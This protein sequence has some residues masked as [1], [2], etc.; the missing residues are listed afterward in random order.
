MPSTSITSQQIPLA[1]QSSV[2]SLMPPYVHGSS[3]SWSPVTG[4]HLSASNSS[5]PNA[6]GTHFSPS[7]QS[8]ANGSHSSSPQSSDPQSDIGT[9]HVPELGEPVSGHESVSESEVEVE[10]VSA[11]LV[12]PA[13]LVS[14]A[15][16]VASAELVVPLLSP[17]SPPTFGGPHAIVNATSAMMGLLFM[18]NLMAVRRIR[19]RPRCPR[20]PCHLGKTARTRS[21]ASPNTGR[22]RA[23]A[24]KMVCSS[25]IHR[26]S[27]GPRQAH[28]CCQ[29][30]SR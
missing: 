19:R 24:G 13:E 7:G 29:P 11:E 12:A 2:A 5:A 27:P 17:D 4:T 16:P 21:Q 6:N 1:S 20:W 18:F 10:F 23:R 15:E 8:C 3:V 30:H 22:R 26:T 14:S 28:R 9:K 25:P